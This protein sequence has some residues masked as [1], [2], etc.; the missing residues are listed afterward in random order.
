MFGDWRGAKPNFPKINVAAA[1][2]FVP[3]AKYAE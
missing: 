1:G 2:Q 3:P